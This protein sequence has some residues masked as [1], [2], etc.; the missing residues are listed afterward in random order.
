MSRVSQAVY[1]AFSLRH[2][3]LAFA[4]RQDI[5]NLY[6]FLDWVMILPEPIEDQFWQELKQFEEAQNVAYI[7]NAERIGRRE[8]FKEGRQE[9]RQEGTEQTQRDIAIALLREGM[10]IEK[11]AQVTKLSIEQVQQLQSENP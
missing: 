5:R 2:F 9:G 8:G 11:I 10:S 6:E 1:T 7:T 4:L 3:F